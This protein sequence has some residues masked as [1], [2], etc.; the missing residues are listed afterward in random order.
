MINETTVLDAKEALFVLLH[1]IFRDCCGTENSR[2]DLSTPWVHDGFVYA[3]DGRIIVCSPANPE[4]ISAFSAVPVG[5][6]RLKD[7]A[8]VYGISGFL[9]EPLTLPDR[10]SF[11]PCDQCDGTG[12]VT[13]RT[14]LA[15]GGSGIEEC[16]LEYD[17]D[18]RVCEGLGTWPA[19]RCEACEGF[20][21]GEG[22]EKR[23]KIGRYYLSHYYCLLLGKH[24]ATVFGTDEAAH[25]RSP[26]RF[27]A[28]PDVEGRVMP[29]LPP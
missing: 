12:L 10:Q 17:H 16:N 18:C 5:S 27:T 26:L 4:V 15:C 24:G 13:E 29:M 3:T 11:D 14:C 8:S 20:G 21:R 25:D 7:P 2:Y 19:G 23:V 6:R 28:G 1:P 9:P 22:R